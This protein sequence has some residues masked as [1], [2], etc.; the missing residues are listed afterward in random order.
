VQCSLVLKI[1]VGSTFG[2]CQPMKVTTG[3]EQL[4]G[5]EQLEI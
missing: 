3:E 2:V 4:G 5:F 1:F